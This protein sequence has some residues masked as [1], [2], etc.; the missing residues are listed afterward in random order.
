MQNYPV[1]KELSSGR[2]QNTAS[3]GAIGEVRVV[4]LSINSHERLN[5]TKSAVFKFGRFSLFQK[6]PLFQIILKTEADQDR[7]YF[8][9]VD[10]MDVD[11]DGHYIEQNKHF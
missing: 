5:K 4:A 8:S 3:V 11:Q 9:T 6:D 7:H 2:K 1:G 10:K